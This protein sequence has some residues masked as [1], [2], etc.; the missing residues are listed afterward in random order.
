MPRE[1]MEQCGCLLLVL[2]EYA[3]I[4][5][6]KQKEKGGVSHE[7]HYTLT[8]DQDSLKALNLLV[9]TLNHLKVLDMDMEGIEDGFVC[10]D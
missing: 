3:N 8:F 5:D 7:Y 1:E 4:L 9:F 10:R 2:S 6:R